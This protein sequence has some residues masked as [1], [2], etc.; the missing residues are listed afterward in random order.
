M[1]YYWRLGKHEKAVF[2]KLWNC[3]VNS[4]M[5]HL[6][7]FLKYEFSVCKQNFC[8]SQLK[9]E[10]DILIN[11]FASVTVEISFIGKGPAKSKF[12]NFVENS[13]PTF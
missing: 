9:S 11:S 1:D 12:T 13:K 7:E 4:P 8:V 2:S 10:L 3:Q 5:N 6:T